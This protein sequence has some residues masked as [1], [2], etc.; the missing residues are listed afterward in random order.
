MATN[1]SP[2]IVTNGLVLSLDAADKNS[3]PGSGTTWYDLSGNGNNGT[4][5][6]ATIGTTAAGTMTFNGTNTTITISSPNLT[7]S[8]FTVIG[9]S[10][11]TSG[12]GRLI[13][14][15]SNNWLLG[16]WST[17]ARQYYSLGWVEGPYGYN[18]TDTHIFCG[19]GDISGDLY[20]FYDNNVNYTTTTT[21][22]SAG[23]NGFV[24]GKYYAGTEWGTGTI[25][26]LLVYDRILTSS[27]MTQN[28]NAHR[29]RFGV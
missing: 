9:V 25:T 28:F 13:S 23:P 20:N 6:A 17:S 14:G 21:G 10:K 12:T 29:H 18:D 27:E 19:T 7:S 16:H 4:L 22:G 5:S 26:V 2:K 24:L 1:Y 8:N 15:G 3:Y 11:R